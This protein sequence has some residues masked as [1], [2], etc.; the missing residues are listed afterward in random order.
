MALW[1]GGEFES[2]GQ[3]VAAAIS[4]NPWKVGSKHVALEPRLEPRLE[5]GL[6]AGERELRA[7]AGKDLQPKRRAPEQIFSVFGAR[8]RL[9][10]HGGGNPESWDRTNIDAV[11]R[12][13]GDTDH[14]QGVLVNEE[15][16]ADD[17]RCS[18]K[19][20]LPE[21]MREDDNRTGAGSSV[22]RLFD[23][24]AQSGA[25]AEHREIA[26]GDD[27]GS[28]RFRI[29]ARREIHLDFSAAEDAVEEASLLLEVT[30]HRVRHQVPGA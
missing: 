1:R 3:V 17:V 10:V 4:R 26:A 7:K 25:D 16:A 12:R 15:F 19:L 14:R 28:D 6:G 30:A 22:I 27:F 23:Q 20:S 5:T 2:G 18:A 11:E 21:I 13:C 9:R 29:A 24:A 8:E